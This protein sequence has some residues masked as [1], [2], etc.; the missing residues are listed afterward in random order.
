MASVIEM[1]TLCLCAS[2]ESPN[3]PIAI[4]C[5]DWREKLILLD[6]LAGMYE[7]SC[8]YGSA[9]VKRVSTTATIKTE[10]CL[11][12]S[13]APTDWTTGCAYRFACNSTFQQ[14][15]QSVEKAKAALQDRN[16]Y[17]T[18]ATA[19]GD[20]SASPFCTPSRTSNH[21]HTQLDI[22]QEELRDDVLHE[23]RSHGT[24]SALF[25]RSS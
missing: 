17:L 24:Y 1:V 5:A 9:L 18:S 13:S 3:I 11:S 16:N 22:L 6:Y 4:I 21:H 20:F 7:S 19:F 25:V 14:L 2:L 8:S 15:K 12:P 10:E 23:K